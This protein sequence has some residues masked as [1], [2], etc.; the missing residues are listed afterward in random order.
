MCWG[1]NSDM[2]NCNCSDQVCLCEVM[3]QEVGQIVECLDM[4]IIIV[5][6]QIIVI[7]QYVEELCDRLNLDVQKL[8]QLN[9]LECEVDV[10]CG[11]YQLMLNELNILVQWEIFQCLFV[12]VIGQVVFLDEK[13][14]FKGMC[15]LIFV[16][17]GGL[18]IG[19][20]LVFLCEVMDNWLLCIL[21]V[22]EG[23][24]LCYLGMLFGVCLFYL[25]KFS[26]LM[27]FVCGDG[28]QCVL[29]GFVVELQQCCLECGVL[30]MGV[31]FCCWGEGWVQIVGWLLVELVGYDVCV[32]LILIVLEYVWLFVGQ[33]GYMVLFVLNQIGDVV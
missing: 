16:I 27:Q 26:G 23:L 9:V 24:G 1:V 29:C 21:D 31:V 22:C 7:E 28:V 11:F 5:C 14:L 15:M 25:V 30:V 32:V 4:Q 8:I 13:F 20:V 12:C 33:L 10:K 17:F 3:M 2:V 19:L 18:V 6:C